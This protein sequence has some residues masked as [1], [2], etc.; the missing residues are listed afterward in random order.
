MPLQVVTS[1]PPRP[2]WQTGKAHR[3]PFSLYGGALHLIYRLHFLMT[4]PWFTRPSMTSKSPLLA[5]SRALPL[6]LCPAAASTPPGSIYR[7]A[8]LIQ[9]DT[10]TNPPQERPSLPTEVDKRFPRS[11]RCRQADQRQRVGPEIR[12]CFR[13]LRVL[14]T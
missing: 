13:V 6:L 3:P 12:G 1:F 7:V 10:Y 2:F 9:Y 11:S 5:L 4:S 14:P 8:T